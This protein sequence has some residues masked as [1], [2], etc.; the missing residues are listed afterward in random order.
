M[1]ERVLWVVKGGREGTTGIVNELLGFW[2]L[3]N[4]P[5]YKM[6]DK[7][8]T[9]S[10]SCHAVIETADS[11]LTRMLTDALVNAGRPTQDHSHE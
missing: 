6:T 4:S 1:S 11:N 10:A 7:Q 2:F 8:Q 9:T 5:E 3:G